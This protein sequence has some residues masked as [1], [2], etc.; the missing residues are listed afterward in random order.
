M[1]KS[2]VLDL[3]TTLSMLGCALVAGIFFAFST[4]VMTALGRLPP[5][6]GVAAMQSINLVVINRW[7]LTVFFGTALMCVTVMA[8]TL[9]QWHTASGVLL[10]AGGLLY[11]VGTILVT[12]SFN[13]PR[14]NALAAVA[15]Q[16]PQAGALWARYLS[17]WTA[18]NHVRTI[19]AFAAA[20]L[21]S[22]A[23]WMRS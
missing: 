11:V 17:S 23:L 10:L 1:S 16:D 7:F 18:W 6:Q 21:F 4:F 20:V 22:I 12:M 15:P 14:N 19:A 8:A 5:A 3:I 2:N 13:V 9:A